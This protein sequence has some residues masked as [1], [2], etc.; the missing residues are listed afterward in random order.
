MGWPKRIV[1]VRHG[2]STGNTLTLEELAVGGHVN[3]LYPLTERG[4]EQVQKTGEYLRAWFVNFDEYFVSTYVRTQQTLKH[5]FPLA[6]PLIDSRLNEQSRGIWSY[7]AHDKVKKLYPEEEGIRKLQG[8]YH[9]RAT[10]GQNCQDV[11]IFAYS[12][13]NTLL[14][15][16]E[17]KNVLIAAH[18]N[19]ALLFWRIVMNKTIHEVEHRYH[20]N[21]FKNASV[22]IYEGKGQNLVITKDNYVPFA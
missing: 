1:I 18:G 22:T 4:I 7:M 5:M 11:E 20:T 10:G 2:E 15:S 17:G 14:Q 12:F 9:Y 16:Y 8:W 3:H 13:I 21:R 6:K 19:W